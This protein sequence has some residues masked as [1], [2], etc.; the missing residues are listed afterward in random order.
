MNKKASDVRF[1][2]KADIRSAKRHVRFTGPISST[3]SQPNVMNATHSEGNNLR[4]STGPLYKLLRFHPNV[5][6][7]ILAEMEYRFTR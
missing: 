2:S 5:K 1:G 7:L 4:A 3:A 6:G